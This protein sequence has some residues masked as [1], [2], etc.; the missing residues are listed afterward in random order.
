MTKKAVKTNTEKHEKEPS[1][2]VTEVRKVKE[3]GTEE[4]LENFSSEVQTYLKKEICEEDSNLTD[5]EFKSTRPKITV[6][7][8]KNLTLSKQGLPITEGEI[9]EDET[10]D[11][12]KVTKNEITIT[13]TQLIRTDDGKRVKQIVETE[14]T[15]KGRPAKLDKKDIQAVYALCI[16]IA[17]W[18]IDEQILK[19]IK[20]LSVGKYDGMKISRIIN[21]NELASIIYS[22]PADKV[23]M[24]DKIEVYKRL[25]NLSKFRQELKG[26]GVTNDEEEGILHNQIIPLGD[27]YLGYVGKTFP[28]RSP[29]T[30]EISLYTEIIFS[31]LFFFRLIGANGESARF[32]PITPSIMVIRDTEIRKNKKGGIMP[33]KILNNTDVFWKVFNLLN[34][35][36]WRFVTKGVA[37]ARKGAEEKIKEEGIR[38]YGIKQ[39]R[40]NEATEKGLVFIVPVSK[41][42]DLLSDSYRNQ[43]KRMSKKGA[44]G[45]FWIELR[46]TLKALKIVGYL[47]E[48]SFI[49]VNEE[50]PE[51]S[52]VYFIYNRG[53][54]K[55]PKFKIPTSNDITESEEQSE[56]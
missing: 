53:Y 48:D 42:L 24:E 55:L 46:D 45:D 17:R 40:I 56:E 7:L 36:R 39:K 13:D 30:G 47:D 15:F 19:H 52:K 32:T 50:K 49:E 10:E 5:E 16:Y 8:A 20:E 18:G 34:A 11:G 27:Q 33:G 23:R 2:V 3:E 14:L 28:A 35:D 44:K 9:E 21:L 29:K 38:N 22:I 54:A 31:D 1:L 37:D 4:K 41:I 43:R 6:A 51:E 12:E 25:W 26:I